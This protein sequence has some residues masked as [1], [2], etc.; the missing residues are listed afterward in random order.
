MAFV[1][2]LTLV[3]A[4]LNPLVYTGFNKDF[5]KAIGQTLTSG[6]RIVQCCS[7]REGGL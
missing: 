7:T 4:A 6:L 2:W 1:M 5:R 3:S